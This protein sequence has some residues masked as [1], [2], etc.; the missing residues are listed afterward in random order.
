MSDFDEEAERERLRQ[1]YEA[2]AEKRETTERMSELLLQGATMT[3]QHCNACHSPVFAYQDQAF[4]PTCQ[5][6]IDESGNP[7]TGSDAAEAA[8][9]EQADSATDADPELESEPETARP[10]PEAARSEPD[11]ETASGTRIKVNDP[12]GNAA[13][14]SDSASNPNSSPAAETGSPPE[15]A[16]EPT[17]PR[18]RRDSPAAEPT[19]STDPTSSPPS[20]PSATDSETTAGI[21]RARTG[22]TD[23][24]DETAAI[25]LTA[26]QAS[27]SRT[28]TRLSER[29]EQS[30]DLSRTRE[31]LL[32]AREA[33]DALAA[34]KQARR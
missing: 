34:L 29:A 23:R 22:R 19:A 24:P 3:N 31:H 8:E 14:D 18:E 32:A 1:Q 20:S 25:D 21:D 12:A 7:V 10:G 5:A 2:D 28:L 33:A 16:S 9:A 4:C 17:E 30:E 6:E 15:P 11:D 26:A 13:A 27:L